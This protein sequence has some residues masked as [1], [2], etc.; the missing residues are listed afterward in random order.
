MA[1]KT[2]TVA[3]KRSH[4]IVGGLV[5]ALLFGMVLGLVLADP[6]A[7]L[8][9]LHQ[10][11]PRLCRGARLVTAPTVEVPAVVAPDANANGHAEIVGAVTEES[12]SASL[13]VV[14]AAAEGG[15]VYIHIDSP[16]GDGFAMLTWLDAVDVARRTRHVKLVCDAGGIVASAAAIIFTNCDERLAATTTVFLYHGVSSMA[17]GKT[18]HIEDA[19]QMLRAMEM[20]VAIRIAPKLGMTPEAYLSWTAGRDRWLVAQELAKMDVALALQ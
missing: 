13:A 19:L 18:T 14:R 12:L 17:A 10:V 15:T 4:E 3:A 16:G 8:K 2:K 20:A 11:L 1:K 9:A 7:T 5:I 6:S